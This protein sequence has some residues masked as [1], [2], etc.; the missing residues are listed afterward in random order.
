MSLAGHP[1]TTN[2]KRVIMSR[3]E[4]GLFRL[5]FDLSLLTLPAKA[6][7][8]LQGKTSFCRYLA[9]KINEIGWLVTC[10]FLPKF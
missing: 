4:L 10:T 7:E 6:V 5:F 3:V 8:I 2:E 9:D 1:K